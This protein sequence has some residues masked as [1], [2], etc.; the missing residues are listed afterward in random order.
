MGRGVAA[1]FSLVAEELLEPLTRFS[2][3]GREEL[4]GAHKEGIKKKNQAIPG[5]GILDV[6]CLHSLSTLLRR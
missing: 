1:T 6:V 2:K 5:K 4:C 3:S